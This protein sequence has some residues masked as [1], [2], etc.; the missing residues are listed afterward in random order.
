M[1]LRILQVAHGFPPSSLAG[2]EV[3][4][5]GLSR[6]LAERGHRVAVFHRVA[7]PDRPEM[8]R[9]RAEVDGLPVLR[10]NNTFRDCD[11]FERTYRND[12]IDRMFD[13][14]LDEERPDV[15][16]FHHVTCLSTNLIARAGRRGIPVVYTLHDY[17]LICQRGQFL[18]RDLSVCPGQEDTECV[19]CLA[20]QL[21]L[22]GSR[23]RLTG[24]LK[25]AAPGVERSAAWKRLLKGTYNLGARL[26]LRSPDEARA[27]VRARMEHVV[28]MCGAV[29]RFLAPSRFLRDRFVEFGIPEERID[30]A[31]YGFDTSFYAVPRRVPDGRIRFGYLG[32]WIPPKGLHVLIE[33]FNGIVD[34]RASLH[35]FGHAVPYEEHEDYA[36]RLRDAVRSPRIHLEGRY[37]N[38]GV[39]RILAGL[40]ALVVPSIWYENAPLTIQ[41]AFLAGVPVITSDLGGMRE[42]VRDG[43]N[44]LTFRSRDAADLRRKIELLI[45]DAALRARLAPDPGAVKDLATSAREHEELFQRLAASKT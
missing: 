23:S 5:H 39:G 27:L 38:R 35:I 19:R 45:N 42:L 11:R 34:E 8:A 4:A 10:V 12:V 15:V 6:A 43:E 30:L 33:A 14:F 13:E 36:A 3:F 44:G 21:N 26:F 37:D 40:D 29:D 17:W 2:A 16:Q 9:E 31:P 7:D 20:W 28:E 1:P 25:R 22:G 41:E 32:T 24:A 18:K